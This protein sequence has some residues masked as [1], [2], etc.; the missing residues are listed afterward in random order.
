MR[1]WSGSMTMKDG[2]RVPLTP[3]HAKAI[4]EA[5]KKRDAQRQELM[6][7]EQDALNMM[8]DAFHRLKELGWREA[9]YCPKDGSTFDVIEPGSSG[10]HVAHYDGDWPDGSWWVHDGD[11]WPSRP[12]L[13]RLTPTHNPEKE[14]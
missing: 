7:T 9:M 14:E 3:E 8:T 11:L 12:C 4:F 1:E 10:I 13:F 2:T 6:P 5:A